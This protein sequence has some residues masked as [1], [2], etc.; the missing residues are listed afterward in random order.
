MQFT[1]QA[2]GEGL[3]LPGPDFEVQV[4][5]GARVLSP[6]QFS[7]TDS[8]F[9]APVTKAHLA[10]LDRLK[11]GARMDLRYWENDEQPPV[12]WR[13]SLTG[14]RVSIEALEA[15]CDLP[16]FA[17][18]ERSERLSQDPASEI[19]GDMVE[20][21]AAL[22]GQVAEVEGYAESIDLDGAAPLDLRVNH[23]L[24]ACSTAEDMVC[25]PAGCLTSLWQALPE[26]GYLRVFQNAVRD[27]TPE[28]AGA[29]RLSLQG[30]LCGRRN[31]PPC[32]RVYVLDD[33][34]LV[35][36]PPE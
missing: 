7:A 19:L 13:F 27:V 36:A 15:V 28:A 35:P 25:G 18:Q 20:A 32:E 9:A 1:L 30:S 17:G 33:D 4:F 22:D 12:R 29:V 14:S 34:T 10:G 5:V 23:G 2:E 8:G 6:M 24:L 3:S 31:A 21:C 16:D 26:G 11:A